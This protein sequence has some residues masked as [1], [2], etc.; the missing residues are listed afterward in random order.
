MCQRENHIGGFFSVDFNVDDG[1]KVLP[2]GDQE[3]FILT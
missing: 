2:N 3:Y 1:F